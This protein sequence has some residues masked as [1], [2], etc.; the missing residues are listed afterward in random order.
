MGMELYRHY[1]TLYE[2]QSV[3]AFGFD[4]F[5]S[6]RCECFY[7]DIARVHIDRKIDKQERRV[8]VYRAGRMETE[9]FFRRIP[10]RRL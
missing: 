7:F 9:H 5:G 10:H 4:L 2:G 6:F 3:V 1:D 8:L